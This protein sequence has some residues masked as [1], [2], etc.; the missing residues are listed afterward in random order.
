MLLVP[1]SA[2]AFTQNCV[3]V[4]V[5]LNVM[6]IFIWRVF[7]SVEV[8][9]DCSPCT[10]TRT[11]PLV[12][13][14]YLNPLIKKIPSYIKDTNDFLSKLQQLDGLSS[15]SSWVTL[16]VISLYTNILDLEGLEACRE[17]LNKQE[18]LEP[19]TE[20]IV[21]LTLAILKKIIFPSTVC[22]VCRN[23][24]LQWEPVWPR[25]MQ[26]SLWASLS[27]TFYNGRGKNRPFGGGL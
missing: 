9:M 5:L 27:V 25:L 14:H 7:C 12:Q 23:K 1:Q 21:Q 10:S 26:I 15:E 13:D 2:M 24:E 19:P 20:D 18:F 16:D 6:P 11:V 3:P 17:T 22:I 4:V 8:Y